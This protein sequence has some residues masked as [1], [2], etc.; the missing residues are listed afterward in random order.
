MYE[1]VGDAHTEIYLEQS[2]NALLSS[3]VWVTTV[4]LERSF[5]SIKIRQPF[6]STRRQVRNNP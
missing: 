4:S 6:K 3:V 1:L 5:V 2:A